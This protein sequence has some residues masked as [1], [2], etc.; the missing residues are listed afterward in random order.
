[1]RMKIIERHPQPQPVK[2]S[3]CQKINIV[4]G[5]RTKRVMSRYDMAASLILYFS[6]LP[7]GRADVKREQRHDA[8]RRAPARIGSG[9]ICVTYPGRISAVPEQ[10]ERDVFPLTGGRHEKKDCPY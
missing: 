8:G 9:V 3:K 6:R 4:T 10:A 5:R 1:M 2:S 7:Q